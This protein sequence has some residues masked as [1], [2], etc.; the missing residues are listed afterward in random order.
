[1][2]GGMML[3]E[4]KGVTKQYPGVRALDTVDFQ[5]RGGEV[6]CLAGEN[7]AG[8]S[9]LIEIIGGS[10]PKDSGLIRLKGKDVSFSSPKHAQE[11][12]IAVLHQELPVLR[13]LSVAENIFLGRQPRTRF[14]MINYREMYSQARKWLGMIQ[15]DIDPR[16]TLGRLPVSKQQLVSIAKAI[17]LQ[18]SVI[19]FDEPSAV[20][21]TAELERLFEIIASFKV[22]GRGIVYISHRLEEIFEIGDRVTVLRNGKLVGS[23][24][25]GNL[26]RESLVRLIV[27]HEVSEEYIPN[28][29]VDRAIS[30]T[31]T[32]H[33]LNRQGVIQD[34]NLE[35]SRS[36]I[37]GIY[38]LL[39]SG[40]TEVAR[41]IIG[42]D[43][44]DSGE[45]SLEGRRLHISSP[46]DAIR[47]GICLVPEDRKC[48][49]VLL[50]KSIAENIALPSLSNLKGLLF[51]NYRKISRYAVELMNKLHIAAPNSN[52]YVKFLSGGNQQK[53]VLAKWIGMSLKVFIFDE[54]TRGIDIGAKEEIRARIRELAQEGKIII[55]ISSEISEILSISDR[56]GVMHEGR[57]VAVVDRKDATKEKLVNYSMGGREI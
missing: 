35:V 28:N 11:C 45:I 47:N 26:T 33:R 9:T 25:I 32:V 14:G 7:G 2:S 43:P 44:V 13:D 27:G 46:R 57:M 23:E 16:S 29:R 50:E 17:S 51:V 10:Y 34:I 55:L 3:L 38:G 21:T 30:P 19:I 37:F 18:A 5:V 31:F 22:E 6:H 8:K 49:G 53:V 54:A 41:A 48:Q 15:A 36:E 52:Q 20:L 1:M 12:G 4:V 39:G 24:P 40:R 42:A 56:I